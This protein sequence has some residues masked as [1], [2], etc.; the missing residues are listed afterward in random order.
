MSRRAI[1]V[2]G[3][4]GA[5]AKRCPVC[6]QQCPHCNGTGYLFTDDENGAPTSTPCECRDWDRRIALY[7][8]ARLPRR[9]AGAG[10]EPPAT[11]DVND[12]VKAARIACYKLTADFRPGDMGIGLSGPVG[13]GKTHLMAGIVRA[14][15]LDNAVP[16]RFIEFTHL[17]SEIKQGYEQGQGETEIIADLAT[18]P[19]LVIDELGKGLSTEWQTTILDALISRRYNLEVTTLFTT[20][21]PYEAAASTPSTRGRDEFKHASLSQKIGTRMASRLR[22]MTTW[23]E[24]EAPDYRVAQG[25]PE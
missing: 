19:V 15:T 4:T 5:V 22:E 25:Q 13:T 24:V 10:L 16:C 17:L 3:K 14:L 8:A 2:S 18:V 20:N 7:N 6:A 21:F 12:S 9:Y 23:L 11:T 1:A